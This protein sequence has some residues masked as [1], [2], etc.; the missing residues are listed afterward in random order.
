MN[1]KALERF[2]DEFEYYIDKKLYVK[3]WIAL[4]NYKKVDCQKE[5]YK[6]LKKLK[7]DMRG[8]NDFDTYRIQIKKLEKNLLLDTNITSPKTIQEELNI[9]LNKLYASK[10]KAEIGT[11]QKDN[12]K[13]TRLIT[14]FKQSGSV[15][16]FIGVKN[17]V[18]I[19]LS[20]IPTPRTV[21]LDYDSWDIY[22][23]QK[24]VI[25]YF[26][27]KISKN[28]FLSLDKIQLELPKSDK[29]RHPESNLLRFYTS[30]PQSFAFYYLYFKEITFNK[31]S[32]NER[33]DRQY[34]KCFSMYII[35]INSF[36]IDNKV[37]H[38]C[39]NDNY[40]IPNLKFFFDRAYEYVKKN[41]YDDDV[42]IPVFIFNKNFS[43]DY[44]TS[45]Y[46]NLTNIPPYRLIIFNNHDEIAKMVKEATDTN[47]T[48]SDSLKLIADTLQII[49]KAEIE[50]EKTSENFSDYIDKNNY[51]NQ[52]IDIFKR[53]LN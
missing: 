23:F 42:S 48:Q 41:M 38:I 16:K 7:Q 33:K 1:M 53:Y 49:K 31:P 10:L 47:N 34:N 2:I 9:L 29:Y 43:E 22:S 12:K 50:I 44:I 52:S 17:L 24:Y 4:Q 11:Y 18:G 25:R 46:N 45:F 28:T 27:L 19:I 40:N 35:D 36:S 8:N 51:I 26:N 3:L 32:P 15:A 39:I 14:D 5:S 30:Q 20:A 13:L 21:G 37:S 6:L